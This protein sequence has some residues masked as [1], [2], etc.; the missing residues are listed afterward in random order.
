MEDSEAS[1]AESPRFEVGAGAETPATGSGVMGTAPP[2]CVEEVEEEDSEVHFKRKREGSSRRKSLA[3]KPRRQAPTIVVEGHPS[4]AIPPAAPLAAEP[5]VAEPTSGEFAP[6]L[7]KINP[8][9]IIRLF[10]C[11]H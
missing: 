10:V 1:D 3:K 6:G 5:S 11:S 8:V 4:T 9:H 2:R 7:G